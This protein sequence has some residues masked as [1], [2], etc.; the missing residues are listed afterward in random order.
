V[1]SANQDAQLIF[2]L[3]VEQELAL[4]QICAHQT[5]VRL[6]LAT[7]VLVPTMQESI[8]L[9]AGGLTGRLADER[10]L[11]HA[12]GLSGCYYIATSYTS[13]SL[14]SPLPSPAPHRRAARRVHREGEDGIL[15]LLVPC[16]FWVRTWERSSRS[17]GSRVMFTRRRPRP[18][19]L[20][21]ALI[22]VAE[23]GVVFEDDRRRPPLRETSRGSAT[24]R[25]AGA[26]AWTAQRRRWQLEHSSGTQTNPATTPTRRMTAGW[27]R[28]SR[29]SELRAAAGAAPAVRVGERGGAC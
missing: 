4:G 25:S 13:Y 1:H 23:E 11:R 26:R 12:R 17:T 16:Y 29:Q 14:L 18:E 21:K 22:R 28:G 2:K 8:A 6:A 19:L 3:S 9:F 10:E 5:D 27:W 24:P 7:V 15:E 20:G